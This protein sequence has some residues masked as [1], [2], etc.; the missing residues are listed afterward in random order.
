MTKKIR[1]DDEEV[2]ILRTFRLER[3]KRGFPIKHWQPAWS[4]NT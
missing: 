4:T 3:S 2:A 1:Y